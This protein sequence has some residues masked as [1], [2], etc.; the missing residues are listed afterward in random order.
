MTA[1]QANCR[2]F[3]LKYLKPDPF[4]RAFQ[5]V[6]AETVVGQWVTGTFTAVGTTLDIV[7]NNPESTTYS[8]ILS[9]YQ[10]RLTAIPEPSTYA[11]IV[12]LLALGLAFSRRKRA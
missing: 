2:S 7:I 4:F 11:S 9:G 3:Q 8:A 6:S 10:L 1:F 5:N 12:G